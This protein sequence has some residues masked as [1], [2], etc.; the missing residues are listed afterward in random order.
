M[1]SNR[2][3]EWTAIS[4][5]MYFFLSENAEKNS[6]NSLLFQFEYCL[7][8]YLPTTLFNIILVRVRVQ[9][10]IFFCKFAAFLRVDLYIC[11][12]VKQLLI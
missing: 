9:L 10:C 5:D 11:L 12:L 2:R 7:T 1:D 4:P 8:I 6:Y 3:V